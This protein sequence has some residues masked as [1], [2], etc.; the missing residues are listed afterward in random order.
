MSERFDRLVERDAQFRAALPDLAVE[1]FILDEIFASLPTPPF[2]ANAKKAVASKVYSH[3]WQHP[4]RG[5]Y[6]RA[7]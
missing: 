7:A 1:V 4:L 3:V 5:D 6:A 2:T